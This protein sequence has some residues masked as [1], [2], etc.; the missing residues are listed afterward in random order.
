MKNVLLALILATL[1][2]ACRSDE[3]II[4]PQLLKTFDSLCKLPATPQNNDYDPGLRIQIIDDKISLHLFK[5]REYEC[6]YLD[7]EGKFIELFLDNEETRS[8]RSIND[9]N[10]IIAQRII[11][12]FINRINQ[13]IAVDNKIK[14]VNKLLAQDFIDPERINSLKKCRD[15][16][17]SLSSGIVEYFGAVMIINDV[18][19]TVNIKIGDYYVDMGWDFTRIDH[20]RKMRNHENE[21][22]LGVDYYARKSD[23]GSVW[24][25]TESDLKFFESEAVLIKNLIKTAWKTN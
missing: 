17:C 9:L 2:S 6:L 20:F 22:L 16:L 10:D 25:M 3:V 8:D 7:S 4:D 15:S 5:D 13:T 1:F 11:N 12:D 18:T 23:Y 24:K 19:N 21:Y 14:R